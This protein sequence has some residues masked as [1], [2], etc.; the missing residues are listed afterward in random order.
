MSGQ[1]AHSGVVFLGQF[2]NSGGYSVLCQNFAKAIYRMGIPLRI[3]NW[4]QIIP[5]VQEDLSHFFESLSFT[6]V[7][8]N[9]VLLICDLPDRFHM[10]EQQGISRMVGFTL[11]ETDR[12]PAGWA[13]ECNAMDNII[14]PSSFNL[15][16]FVKYGVNPNILKKVPIGIDTD[17]FVPDSPH[18]IPKNIGEAKGRFVFLY[19]FGLHYRKGFGDLLEAYLREFAGEKEVA[20]YLSCFPVKS[21]VQRNQGKESFDLREFLFDSISNRSGLPKELEMPLVC[22]NEEWLSE[23]ELLGLYDACDIYFSTERASGW[24]LPC[25]E[26]MAMGKPVAAI[27]WGGSTE[28]MNDDNAFLIRT[29]GKM[30]PVDSRLGSKNRWY[31][32]HM[33]PEVTIDEIR[34]V[35]RAAF[36]NDNLR[37]KKAMTGMELVR[38]EYSLGTIGKKIAEALNIPLP[39]KKG[40][41]QSKPSEDKFRLVLRENPPRVMEGG[42][43]LPMLRRLR[44]EGITRVA[45]Y[46]A[47]KNCKNILRNVKVEG[48]EYACIIDDEKSKQGRKIRGIPVVAPEKIMD[49]AP[50]VL[51]I[52]SKR[53]VEEMYLKAEELVTKSIRILSP[54]IWKRD[55]SSKSFILDDPPV[56]PCGHWD[57]LKRKII[58]IAG[59]FGADDFIRRAVRRIYSYRD[60]INQR[61]RSSFAGK[62]S[63]LVPSNTDQINI[64]SKLSQ[65]ELSLSPFADILGKLTERKIQKV[66]LFG[67][68][69]LTPQL[70]KELPKYNIKVTGIIES[71]PKNKKKKFDGYDILPLDSL[72]DISVDGI[73]V[74]ELSL[75]GQRLACELLGMCID[76]IPIFTVSHSENLPSIVGEESLYTRSLFKRPQEDERKRV[77]KFR[78]VLVPAFTDGKELYE[79]YLRLLW[80]LPEQEGVE[81]IFPVEDRLHDTLP[82][83]ADFPRP[84]KFGQWPV[85]Y[86]HIELQGVDSCSPP[87]WL[88]HA[89]LVVVW[90]SDRLS[91]EYFQVLDKLPNI[92]LVDKNHKAMRSGFSYAYLDYYAQPKEIILERRKKSRQNMEKAAENV[93]S[94]KDVYIFGTGPSLERAVDFDFS[95]GIRIVCN[96]IV[97]NDE[98]LDYIRPHF[99]IAAD[100]DFH[101]GC[102][103]YAA[104]F[105][106]DLVKALEKTGAMFVCPEVHAPLMLHHYPQLAEHIIGI[107]VVNSRLNLDLLKKFWLSAK[108]NVMVQF[109]IPLASS[110]GQRIHMIGFD[111]KKP[112]DQKF[113]SHDPASQY[114]SLMKSVEDCHPA[115]FKFRNYDHYFERHCKLIEDIISF[116]ER[117]GREFISLTDSVIPALAYRSAKVG[118][119]ENYS[120]A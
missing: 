93:S 65:E 4:G 119:K 17:F 51:V 75:S 32:G 47:G 24:S 3:V 53:Y 48:I 31:S 14:V 92:L 68:G 46:G 71:S 1:E 79:E 28:Y 97:K 38:S 9:P 25:M 61:L 80:F 55:A 44:R 16:T 57:T 29:T 118:E 101:F 6:D 7:G 43:F 87:H 37:K 76:D 88:E 91:N 120:K 63:A 99:I 94:M 78:V 39:V 111:G 5:Q 27:D 22:I 19:R 10:V 11:F 67:T 96:T 13:Q 36:E 81:V 110:I 83:A 59:F 100:A 2:L 114:S 34:R 12:I 113:W 30:V 112:E 49:F 74:N 85:S 15:D 106:S 66:A 98:L 42:E 20:L 58:K 77:K 116:G 95:N 45:I 103:C 108:D 62:P 23:R 18:K 41:H 56:K 102:S 60:R 21:G 117:M 64:L 104:Q 72:A 33:W 84:A 73:V 35:M 26:M 86:Q 90:N 89:R 54:Y 109:L 107:P 82:N 70:L 69:G 52:S 115:F 40:I 8:E 105:R 50:Q